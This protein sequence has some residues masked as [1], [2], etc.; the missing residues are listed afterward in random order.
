MTGARPVAFSLFEGDWLHRAYDAAGLGDGSRFALARRC[1]L[2]VLVTWVP[3]ALL[4]WW[5]GLYGGGLSPTNFFADFAAYAQLVMAMPLF[6]ASER[7]IDAST[8]E[9]AEQLV[10]CGI[11]RPQDRGRLDQA[12]AMVARARRSF[13]PDIGCIV[14]A[15]TLSLVILV[16]EFGP[17][18]LPTWHVKDYDHWRTLT[19][20][21]AWAFLVALPI[22]NYT[23]LRFAWKIWLW[24][25]YLYKVSRLRLE[26]HPTHPDLTGGI[27]FL[28]EAQG[29]FALFILAYGVSNVAAT[30]GYEVVIL[31]YSLDTMTVW[32]P[33]LGFAIGAP[34]LFTLPLLMFTRQLHR[35]KRQALAT[36]RQRVTERSRH[37]ESRWLEDGRTEQPASEEIRELAELATLH[38]MF[39]HID[40]M[41]V[42]P[43]DLR[44]FGQLAGSSFGSI[45]TLLPLLQYDGKVT[46]IFELIAKLLG[47]LV[48]VGR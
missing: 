46:G 15:F 47:G 28:S 22:L 18:P 45:A 26:L 48:G 38:T 3:I 43:F 39:N 35:S 33:L 21:G 16:P 12:H 41:R 27:G 11:V 14:L 25:F 2:S 9:V 31:D 29:R 44:S 24:I 34:L 40:R 37:V 13:W 32:G 6:I 19:P 30:V 20:A 42:V 23:W 10:S 36:Y 8:R 7:V 17:D 5:G 4:A 1:V